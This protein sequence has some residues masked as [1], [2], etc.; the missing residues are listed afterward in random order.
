MCARLGPPERDQLL[1]PV[2]VL[3]REVVRLARVGVGVEQLPPLRGEVAPG[4]GRSWDGGRGL[5]AAVPDRSCSE[6]GEE[7]RLLARRRIRVVQAVGEAD[8][9]DRLLRVPVHLVGGFEVEAL[10][11]RRHDVDGV[12][13][14]AADLAGP[15]DAAGPRHDQR[16]G[17]AAAVVAV[18]LPHLERRVERPRPSGRIV[19][20]GARAAELVELLEVLLDRVGDAVEELVLVHGAVRTALARGTVVGYEHD[21]RVVELAA[22]LQEIEE[23]TELMVGVTE[24]A[25]VDLS[26]ACEQ[27]FL[28]G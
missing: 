27:P 6:H 13:V 24:E 9:L 8:A 1:E 19:V 18:A 12:R 16:V 23:A 4:V 3:L 14:L 11:D 28:V 15:S 20:V 21:Q 17:G 10:V 25:R 5:P 2:R 26:H 7:L 22:P